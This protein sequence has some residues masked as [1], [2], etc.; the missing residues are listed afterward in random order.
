LY[1]I[2]KEAMLETRDGSLEYTYQ[3]VQLLLTL[4]LVDIKERNHD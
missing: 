2:A 4:G 1:E 3:Y